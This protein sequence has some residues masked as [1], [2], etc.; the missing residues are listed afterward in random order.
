MISFFDTITD[1]REMIKR[2]LDYALQL[3]KHIELAT[4]EKM[5]DN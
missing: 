4:R 3:L 1:M 2:N 5:S